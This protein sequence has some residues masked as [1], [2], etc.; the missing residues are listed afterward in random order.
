M[1][2]LSIGLEAQAQA[3]A[4]EGKTV[5]FVA[6]AG[7]VAGIIAVA[8]TLKPEAADAV[9]SLQDFG[10][11]VIIITGDNMQTARAVAGSLG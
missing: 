6:A 5:M 10:L 11:E 9:A 3:L 8:D 1:V 2:C 7:R 4:V